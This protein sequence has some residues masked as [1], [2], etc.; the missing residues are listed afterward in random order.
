MEGGDPVVIL[1]HDNPDPDALA[2]AAALQY[3]LSEIAEV[4]SV[5]A[6]GGIIGRAENRAMVKYLNIKL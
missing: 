2:S 4:D 6:L 1:P 3:L 5:I